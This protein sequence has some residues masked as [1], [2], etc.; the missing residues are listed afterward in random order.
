MMQKSLVISL[1]SVGMLWTTFTDA[2]TGKE[3]AENRKKG[4]CLACHMIVGSTLPGNI[5]P[6]LVAMKARY[7]N[8]ADLRAQIYD[9]RINNPKT[10][11]LPF[12]PHEILTDAEID[13]ITDYI[14]SL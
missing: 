14:Y 8:K 9:A 13:K 3:L 7:P 10:V 11:M 4:N 2:A 6:P 5:A 12:G 1:L